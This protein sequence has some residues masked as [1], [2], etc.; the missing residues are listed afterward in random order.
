M[1][2]VKQTK[3]Q[4]WGLLISPPVRQTLQLKP[5]VGAC[6]P[7]IPAYLTAAVP[8]AGCWLLSGATQLWSFPPSRLQPPAVGGLEG[9]LCPGEARSTRWE[10]SGTS[11]GSRPTP[12]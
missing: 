12:T 2:N 8:G 7:V 9:S 3:P 1:Y 4:G 6:A 11:D 10:P 5:A